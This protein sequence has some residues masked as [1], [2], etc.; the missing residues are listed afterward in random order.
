MAIGK[1][2]MAVDCQL[3]D[4]R[5]PST[6]YRLG[7]FPAKFPSQKDCHIDAE[8]RVGEQTG[9]VQVPSPQTH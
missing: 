1:P 3:T 9:L 2:Q 8:R 5:Q 7:H 6:D 4:N